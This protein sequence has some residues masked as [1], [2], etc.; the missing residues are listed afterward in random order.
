MTESKRYLCVDIGGTAVKTGLLTGNGEILTT[1]EDPAPRGAEALLSLVENVAEKFSLEI[2]NG[3][4]GGKSDKIF[5]GGKFDVFHALCVSTAGIVDPWRGEILPDSGTAVG[6]YGGLPLRAELQKRAGLPVEVENDVN[7]ALLGESWRGAARGFRNAACITVGTGIGGAFM[8]DGRLYRGTRFDAMEVGHIP[9]FPSNWE[10]RASTQ[11]LAC[12]CA[13][14]AG[15]FPTDSPPDLNGRLIVER[16]REGNK[17]ALRA[18]DEL[19]FYLAQG[20]ATL[21]AV[22]APD[23]FVVGGGIAQSQDLLRPRIDACLERTLAPRFREKIALR[24]AELGN[25]A[26]LVGA[27]KHFM[28]MQKTG[29][30][31]MKE[32]EKS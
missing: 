25:S 15:H 13:K 16:A 4:L 9:F 3:Q 23:V 28:D 6:D 29:K 21:F 31:S 22:L 18:V 14:L 26:G 11:A 17:T 32:G 5:H 20:I 19:C 7:C 10:N 27:L 8:I 1:R 2:S 12:A 24:F 30:R